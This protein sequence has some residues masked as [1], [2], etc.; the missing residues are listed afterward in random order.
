MG[1]VHSSALEGRQGRVSKREQ[2]STIA[3]EIL[4]DSGYVCMMYMSWHTPLYHP[5]FLMYF[6]SGICYCS[7]GYDQTEGL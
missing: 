2:R 5:G 3:D 6:F 1:T 4:A 7:Y